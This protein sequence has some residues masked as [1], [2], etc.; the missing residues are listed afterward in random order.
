MVYDPYQVVDMKWWRSKEYIDKWWSLTKEQR[1]TLRLIRRRE[2]NEWWELRRNAHK[3]V[4]YKDL[5]IGTI[6][7]IILP[8]F[9]V[10]YLLYLY[11]KGK[12]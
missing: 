5:T 2:R 7:F 3:W 6:L 4:L 10:Y 11:G 9:I 12:Y 1:H 8:M